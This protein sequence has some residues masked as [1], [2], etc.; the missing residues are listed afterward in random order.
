MLYFLEPMPGLEPG[1][2]SLPRKC[3]TAELHWHYFFFLSGRRGSNPRPSAWKA[4]ALSTELLPQC[5]RRWIRTTEGINQQIYSLP[6]LATLVFALLQCKGT[7]FSSISQFHNHIFFGM[8]CKPASIQLI[9]NLLPPLKVSPLNSRPG[10]LY[11]NPS[12]PPCSETA[13]NAHIFRA[14]TALSLP[15]LPTHPPARSRA[16]CIVSVV[17]TPNITGGRW[18]EMPPTRG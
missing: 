8:Y 7:K 4:D 17:I 2:S 18:I 5:G 12:S 9:Y 15:L 14:V 6:H 10:C 1:T 16:C 3:S 11:Y 13:F